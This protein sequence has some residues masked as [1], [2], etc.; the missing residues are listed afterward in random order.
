MGHMLF[1][2][3]FIIYFCS[4]TSMWRLGTL[5]DSPQID[6]KQKSV[7]AGLGSFADLVCDV[8]SHPSAQVK[9]VQCTKIKF[10]CMCRYK[11]DFFFF[12]LY[13]P[14]CRKA[15]QYPLLGLYV[16]TWFLH[17]C[18]IRVIPE[19]YEKMLISP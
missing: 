14:V 13:H 8:V 4:S 10:S 15:S 1:I 18:I 17:L 5:I 7:H 12:F 3:C 9:I 2:Y 16:S 6:V 11:F 19:C